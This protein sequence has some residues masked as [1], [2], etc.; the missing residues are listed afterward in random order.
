MQPLRRVSFAYIGLAKIFDL[1]HG[2]W[3]HNTHIYSWCTAHRHCSLAMVLVCIWHLP[4]AFNC[5]LSRGHRSP[6]ASID[7]FLPRSRLAFNLLQGDLLINERG[8]N[9]RQRYWVPAGHAMAACMYVIPTHMHARTHVAHE[10]CRP[11]AACSCFC[12]GFGGMKARVAL[13]CP[14]MDCSLHHM[15]AYARGSYTC[16]LACAYGWSTPAD[17]SIDHVACNWHRSTPQIDERVLVGKMGKR[18]FA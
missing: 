4:L 16:C 8:A 2:K 18:D 9:G 15:H 10:S 17:R 12:P 11:G 7:L 5:C 13:P 6:M 14:A 1:G 3:E